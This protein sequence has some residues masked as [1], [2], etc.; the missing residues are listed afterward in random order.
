MQC[1]YCAEEIQDAAIVCRYCRHDLAPSKP[2][3]EE[4]RALLD[5]IEELRSEVA[6]LQASSARIQANTKIIQSRK[7]APIKKTIEETAIYALAPIVLLLLAHFLIVLTWDKPTIYLRIV[8]IAIPMPFGFALIWRERRYFAWA[9]LVGAVVSL[10]AITGMS[11]AVALHDHIPVLPSDAQ[12]WMEELQYFVSIGLAFITG[13]L[14]AVLFRNAAGAAGAPSRSALFAVSLAPRVR[15]GQRKSQR[16]DVTSI[17]ERAESF[18]K[19]LAGLLAAATT[20]G[21][22]YT[23]VA[24]VLN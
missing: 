15:S 19:A 16:P 17:I 7:A 13:G 8:S 14:L 2:L 12:E 11:F 5:E 24:G 9:I 3:I 20:A 4:N 6:E 23:G 18:E 22:I 21:S 10:L 1:P